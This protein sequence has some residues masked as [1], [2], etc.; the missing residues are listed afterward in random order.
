MMWQVATRNLFRNRRRSLMTILAIAISGMAMLLFGGFVTSI[1]FGLQTSIVQEQGHIQ[2]FKRGYTEYGAADPDAYTIDDYE[3]V[4][5]AIRDVPALSR[6]IAVITPQ[7]ALGGIAGNSREDN[8]KTFIGKGVVPSDFNQMRTWDSWRL[9]LRQP[10]ID[11]AGGDVDGAIVGVGMARMIGLC[12][13][14]KVVAC[15]DPPA[16]PAPAGGETADF[17][18]LV[19]PVADAASAAGPAGE[20][21]PRLDLLAATSA[22]APNI[23]SVFVNSAVAQPIRAVDNAMVML[24]FDQARSLLYG[25]DRKATSLVLQAF[26][27]DTVGAL[28]A[29]LQTHLKDAG[30]D[31]EVLT[32]DEVDPTFPRIFGMFSVIFGAV[33]LVLTIVIVFTIINTVTMT[34]MERINEVGTI[35]ALGLRRGSV[36]RQFLTESFLLGLVG[37]LLSLVLGITVAALLNRAG[38]QWTPPSNA[39]PMTIHLMVTENPILMAGTVAFLAL[40]TVAASILPAS[41]AVRIP[42]VR[43]LH[44]A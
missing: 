29:Q 26:D 15:Q 33:A 25:T 10:A 35:R 19:Q 23:V 3:A 32:F 6:Q 43:A 22:G 7:I 11:L 17:S 21:R 39:T 13:E 44:H 18:E 12:D 30:F 16:H 31:L 14:L 28:R 34:V 41:N 2:I 9:G 20:T 5:H 37:A 27:P 36:F 4:Q 42:I 24:H 40:V 38:I 8:S 1:W